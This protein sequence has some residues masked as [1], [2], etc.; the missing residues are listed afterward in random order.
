MARTPLASAGGGARFP[1]I[2]RGA[3]RRSFLPLLT[4]ALVALVIGD[5]IGRLRRGPR[6]VAPA[7][8]PAVAESVTTV[9]G[10]AELRREPASPE[11][12]AARTAARDLLA[13][14]GPTTYL[15]SLLATTDSVVR[16]WPDRSEP[17]RYVVLPGGPAD[18]RPAMSDYVRHAFTVWAGVGVGLRFMEVLD[19]ANADIVVH[20]IDRFDYDRAGQTDLVWDQFG[21]VRRA[22]IALAVRTSAGRILPES[23]LR[24]VALHEAGHALGLPHSADTGDVMFPS[25]RVDS[26]SPRD[27]ATLRLLYELP[28]GSLR[29]GAARVP[30]PP[31]AGPAGATV[32]LALAAPPPP[33]FHAADAAVLRGI[34]RGLYPGAVLVVGRHNRILHARAFGH[35]TWSRRSARPSTATTLWDLASLTKVVATASTTMRLVD[36]GRLS[37]D[38]PVASVLP[39]FGGG[40]KDSVT[41]RMLLDH[42]SGLR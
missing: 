12:E 1:M 32:A 2:L 9:P 42:T 11:A 13:R 38:T 3:M 28:P 29:A 5:Q 27:V 35:F 22:S 39:R 18:Y 36:Q 26:L 23:A 16:R 15:D 41:V 14:E 21:R 25:T 34:R 17:L 10:S 24:S 7:P 19:T 30:P 20:W 31:P 4:I 8:Q 40:A 37:L 33:D 6:A